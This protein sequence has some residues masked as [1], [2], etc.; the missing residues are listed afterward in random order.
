MSR[1]SGGLSLEG[2]FFWIEVDCVPCLCW[3]LCWSVYRPGMPI[4]IVLWHLNRGCQLGSDRHESFLFQNFLEFLEV[5]A[6][7]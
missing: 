3:F 5:G 6:L 4:S 2:R 7:E 1:G